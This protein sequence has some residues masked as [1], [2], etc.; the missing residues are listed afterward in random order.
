[1][2]LAAFVAWL[3]RFALCVTFKQLQMSSAHESD[4]PSQLALLGEQTQVFAIDML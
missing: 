3:G 2:G 4:S 1:M